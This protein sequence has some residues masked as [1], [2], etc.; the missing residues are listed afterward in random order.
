MD[1]CAS[2][3]NFSKPCTLHKS[4]VVVRAL[5]TH[6][7]RGQTQRVLRHESV[8]LSAFDVSALVALPDREAGVNRFE[9]AGRFE[10]TTGFENRFNAS[11]G[12]VF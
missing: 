11:A 4:M 7:H 12:T 5:R 10:K 9:N 1:G 6:S 2:S 8:P 3:T